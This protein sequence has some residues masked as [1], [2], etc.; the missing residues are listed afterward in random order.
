VSFGREYLGKGNE[1]DEEQFFHMRRE[2]FQC[3]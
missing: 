2:I 3:E 1:Q